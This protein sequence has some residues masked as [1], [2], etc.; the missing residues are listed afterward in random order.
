MNDA[1]LKIEA[2]KKVLMKRQEVLSR[3]VGADIPA[4][5]KEWYR[6]RAVGLLDAL[7]LLDSS[8]E[9]IQIELQ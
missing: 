6:G 1:E 3:I 9:S 2:V 7:D 8:L 5:Q 4:S